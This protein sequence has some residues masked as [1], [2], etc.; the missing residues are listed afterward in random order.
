MD[1]LRA[2][3][4]GERVGTWPLFADSIDGLRRLQA[5]APCVATTNSDRHHGEQV[6]AQLGFRLSHWFCAEDLRAYKPNPDVWHTVAARLGIP[7]DRRWWHVSAYGDYDLSAAREL[8]LTCVYVE[9]PHC[10]PGPA[11]IAVRDFL[12]LAAL[13]G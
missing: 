13:I 6:Q 7:L 1:E 4:V 3:G 11:D 9:R 8:G 2:Y 10:R 12:E 5:I